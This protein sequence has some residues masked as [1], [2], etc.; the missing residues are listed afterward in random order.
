[1]RAILFSA[2]APS[3]TTGD[4]TLESVENYGRGERFCQSL[5]VQA[6]DRWSLSDARQPFV[7]AENGLDW[8]EPLLLFVDR[9]EF[10][11]LTREEYL[12]TLADWRIE[13]PPM[14]DGW[15][16]RMDDF[17]AIR[18]RYRPWSEDGE[19]AL[20]SEREKDATSP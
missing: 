6:K 17:L 3:E 11:A 7:S 16:V 15:S 5:L 14:E 4:I 1:M 19:F 2:P 12:S 9:L 8:A 10:R 20:S 13:G 18:A